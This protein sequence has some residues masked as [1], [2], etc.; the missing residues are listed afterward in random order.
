MYLLVIYV[1]DIL[2]I[3]EQEEIA[4]LEKE[5]TKEFWWITMVMNN[6]QSYLGMQVRIGDG[7]ISLDMRYYLEK[8]LSKH[9]NLQVVVGPGSAEGLAVDPSSALLE[10]DRKGKFHTSMAKL[11]YLSKRGRPDVIANIGFLCTRVRAPTEEDWKKLRRGLGYLKGT[12][13]WMMQMKPTGIFRVVGYTDASFLAHPDEESHSGIVVQVGG[14]SVYFGSRKQKCVCKSPTEAELVA[15]LDNLGFVELFGEMLEFMLNM[16]CE[17]PLIYEDNTSVIEMVTSGGGVT[18]TKHMRTRMY[19]VL[20][21]IAEKRVQIKHIG[22]KQMKADGF[23][24][25]LNGAEFTRFRGEVL[26]LTDHVDRW[27]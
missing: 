26:H 21:A 7:K 2:I 8:V 27:T 5:F 9:D 6:E 17:A 25:R 12:K 1:D 16:K 24:K 4:R 22:T 14:V 19:L 18:R 10:E 23:T 15:L 11:L 20:E 3:A 13:N